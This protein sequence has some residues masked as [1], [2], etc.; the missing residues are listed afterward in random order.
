MSLKNFYHQPIF[1]SK[2]KGN[3]FSVI[4]IMFILSA[5][6]QEVENV[7]QIENIIPT[8]RMDTISYIMGYDYGV[9]IAEKEIG[10]NPLLI[11]KG[12]HDALNDR[13]PLLNDTLQ[14]RLIEEFSF[15]LEEIEKQRFEVMPFPSKE[16]QERRVAN[17]SAYEPKFVFVLFAEGRSSQ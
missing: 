3:I 16:S 11:Y 17:Y 14:N 10:A 4:L 7:E 5:C 2:L 15:E 13:Q 9:G 8:T 6:H 1:S 12:L